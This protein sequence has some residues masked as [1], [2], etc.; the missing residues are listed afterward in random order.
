MTTT[1]RQRRF[2][3][4]A[5]LLLVLAVPLSAAALAGAGAASAATAAKKQKAGNCWIEVVNDWLD[6][7]RVDGT[8]PVVCYRQAIQKLNAFPDIQQYSTAVD[9]IHR[10]LLDVETHKKKPA[11]STTSNGSSGP[12]SSGGGSGGGG[13]GGGGGSSGSGGSSGT[14]GTATTTTHQSFITHLFHAIGPGDAQAVPLP[15]L[16]LAGLAVLLLLAAGGTWLAKRFQAR[17]MT[18]APAS[19][20]PGEKH[21]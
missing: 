9:D 15:L 20:P 11:T 1:K 4:V 10:A 5:A 19:V 6:N 7:N 16:V 12:A 21:A 18:P 8:Y 17:R 14:G 3:R 13:S 2:V